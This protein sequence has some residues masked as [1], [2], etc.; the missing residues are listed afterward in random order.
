MQNFTSVKV[1][2]SYEGVYNHLL[3]LGSF[4]TLNIDQDNFYLFDRLHSFFMELYGNP[5]PIQEIIANL[6]TSCD[7]L[8]KECFW[9]GKRQNCST[10][11]KT[12]KTDFGPCCTFNYQRIPSKDM[13][14]IAEQGFPIPPVKPLFVRDSEFKDGLSVIIEQNA[15]DQIYNIQSSMASRVLIFHP[16]DYPDMSTNAYIERQ[17]YLSGELFIELFP[18]SIKGDES[19]RHVSGRVRGCFFRD[20]NQLIFKDFY[21]F[22]ECQL[23]CKLMDMIH[24]CRCYSHQYSN[25]Y[26]GSECLLN[27]IS[28]LIKWKNKWDNYEPLLLDASNIDFKS[29]STQ[30]PNCMPTCNYIKYGVRSHYG[31]VNFPFPPDFLNETRVTEDSHLSVIHVNFALPYAVEYHQ[32]IISTWYDLLATLGGLAGFTIGASL[33]SVVELLWYASGKAG[34]LWTKHLLTE[35]TE[36]KWLIVTSSKASLWPSIDA[37]LGR[38]P[39]S[40][41]KCCVYGD[42]PQNIFSLRGK[43]RF[44]M[45]TNTLVGLFIAGSQIAPNA[46]HVNRFNLAGC[47]SK[48]LRGL[49]RTPPDATM[50]PPSD[51]NIASDVFSQFATELAAELQEI[52][53]LG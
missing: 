15:S 31:M 10:L 37:K 48:A 46:K 32:T 22:S 13:F 12:N 36:H 52:V 21:T 47:T 27:D 28:C 40:V 44:F 50:F 18:E 2:N 33:L 26:N 20:E 34:T 17:V 35:T 51:N 1:S 4:Y 41:P 7:D 38:I 39:R 43:N 16:Q 49:R 19:M 5:Y 24:F 25:I 3:H 14:K 11:F 6:S 30:C 8:L 29:T 9:N 45:A 53:H 23:A 42:C